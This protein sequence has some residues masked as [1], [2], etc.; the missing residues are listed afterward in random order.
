MCIWRVQSLDIQ[1]HAW[2]LLENV[3]MWRAVLCKGTCLLGSVC[4]WRAQLCKGSA[5]CIWRAQL[6]KG[7]SLLANV[8]IWRAHL[9]TTGIMLSF[10]NGTY[11]RILALLRKR[12]TFCAARGAPQSGRAGGS[13][14]RFG[15]AQMRCFRARSIIVMQME[16]L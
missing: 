7:I 9:T 10:G 6:C 14:E 16:Y 4:I 5:H 2:S 15:N 13:E 1:Q 11:L 8:F 3:C 12:C